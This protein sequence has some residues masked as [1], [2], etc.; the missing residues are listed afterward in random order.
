MD[1]LEKWLESNF[2]PRVMKI[3]SNTEITAIKNSVMQVL[4]LIFLGSVFCLLAIPCDFIKW[5]PNFFTGYNWTFGLVSIFIAFLI[6]FNLMELKK[7]RKSR[8]NGGISGLI[9][10]LLSI[11]PQFM[12]DQ[13]T[14]LTTGKAAFS[15]LSGIGGFG[16]GGMFVAIICGLLAGFVV[17]LFSNFSFFKEDSVIPDFVQAWFD[18]MLPIGIVTLA[19]WLLTDAS[20]L[21]LNL[22]QIIV[23]VFM[24]LQNFA[25]QPW[26]F[27]LI[28]F[29]DC[30]IY[31]MGISGWVLA[32][33]ET[34]II[35]GAAAA[36]VAMVQAGTATAATLNFYTYPLVYCTYLWIGGIGCTLPLVLLLMRAKSK[37]LKALGKACIV[38]AI[39]NINEPV[40]FGSIVWNPLLMVPFW[41]QGIILPTITYL[42]TKVIMFAPVPAIMFN[43]WYCPYPI[44]TWLVTR[45]VQ[46]ILLVII[47]FVVSGIIWMPFVR[48]YD[49]QVDEKER[50]EATGV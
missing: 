46:A 36:N 34:P 44:S 29:L 39:F 30:F 6:P 31:S 19:G 32:P 8:L 42:F 12:A 13:N 10:F 20:F 2:A 24:P 49:K 25:Q 1:K 9:L 37:Q 14:A 23:A 35:Y 28:L 15:S 41:L 38:P 16:A 22:Y 18:S 33:L 4:P 3:S 43:L 47:N 26:G 11:N 40:V 50:V 5:W 48:A 21:N 27:I 7:K 17:N 45:S